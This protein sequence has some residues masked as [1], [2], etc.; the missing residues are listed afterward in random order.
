MSRRRS[1]FV[2]SLVSLAASP[3]CLALASCAATP[4]PSAPAPLASSVENPVSK[5]FPAV[6]GTVHAYETKDVLTGATGVLMM[7][8][9]VTGARTIE[10]KSSKVQRL[11]YDD[12]GLLREPQGYYLLRAPLA[13][14][15]SWPAGPNVSVAIVKI[16]A[17]ITVPAGTYRGCVETVDRRVGA[18]SG[19]IKSVYCPDV[20]LVLLESE[21]QGQGPGQEVHERVELKSFDKELDLTKGAPPP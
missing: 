20:G 11:R 7:R 14:G 1:P 8:T 6:D 19:T 17:E 18:V 10:V 9:Q 4:P 13:V 5:F 21:G 3:A 2:R 15:Q 12:K 16:D